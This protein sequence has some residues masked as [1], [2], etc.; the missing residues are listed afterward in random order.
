MLTRN[1]VFLVTLLIYKKKL[2]KIL[3]FQE[4]A[5]L[6]KRAIFLNQFK[7]KRLL[8]QVTKDINLLLN[9]HQNLL[10]S[11]KTPATIIDY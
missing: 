5:S 10:Q 8:R 3:R 9:S 2:D 11:L 6:F 4:E 1:L 7:M